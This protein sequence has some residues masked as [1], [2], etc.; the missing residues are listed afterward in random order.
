[1]GQPH[2]LFRFIFGLFKQTIQFWQQINVKNVQMSI[3]TAPGF[4]PTTFQTWPQDQGSR[5]IYRQV[6]LIDKTIVIKKETK[7]RRCGIK[8]KSNI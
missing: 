4:K 3:Y 6:D 8:N 5:P 7:L 1:M 2:P